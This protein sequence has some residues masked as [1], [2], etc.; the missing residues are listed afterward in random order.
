MT[1]RGQRGFTLIEI[2]VAMAIGGMLVPVVV[3]GIF[4]VTNGT[5][6]INTDL[7]LLQDIDGASAWINRDLSQAQT[8]DVVSGAPPVDHMR[9]DWIDLT[10]WAAEGSESH[11]AEY[12]LSGSDLVR[13][14]DGVTQIVARRI[15]DIAFSRVDNYMTVAITSTLR[16]TTESLSYFVTART[17]G[18]LQ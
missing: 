2:L 4:Q 14:Y 9:V 11:Y 8:T 18:A 10:G 5:D 7:V 6:K 1:P 16:G 15:A 17:D 12:T 13:E 3:A